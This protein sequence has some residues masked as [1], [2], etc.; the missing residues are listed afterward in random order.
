MKKRAVLLLAV[1]ALSASPVWAGPNK[2]YLQLLAEIRMLQEQNQQMQQLFGSLQDSLKAVTAKLDP[3]MSRSSRSGSSASNSR[4]HSGSLRDTC[5]PASPVVQTP[6]K[7]TQSKPCAAM[8][9]SS[10]SG[11]S[12]SPAGRPSEASISRSLTRVLTWYSEG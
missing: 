12:S 8:W 4:R 2:E 1:L 9:S 11:M 6:R 5:R 3:Q 10:A 7:Y